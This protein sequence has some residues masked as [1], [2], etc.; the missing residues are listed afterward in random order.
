MTRPLLAAS[1]LAPL[2]LAA[3]A[4][5]PPPATSPEAPP[6]GLFSGARETSPA[7]TEMLALGHAEEEIDRLFAHRNA[8]AGRPKST[9]PTPTDD[10]AEKPAEPAAGDPCAVACRALASMASSADRLCRLAGE[11]DGRC[12]DARSRVRAATGRVKSA[13]PGCA[14]PTVGS[15]PPAR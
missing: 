14:S 3:C 12:D 5:P 13:C 8:P 11:N 1:L 7:D 6:P 9:G 4:A 15:G 2:W 10:A